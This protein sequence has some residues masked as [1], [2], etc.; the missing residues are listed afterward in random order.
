M[1]DIDSI[2]SGV[3]GNTRAN[4]SELG[5]ILPSYWA[6]LDQKQKQLERNVFKDGIPTNPD[7]SPNYAEA[8]K[9][10]YQIGDVTQ[11]NALSNLDIQRQQLKL[12]QDASA[13]MGQI[14]SGNASPASGTTLPPSAS[15]NGSAVVAPPISGGSPAPAASQKGGATLMQLVAASGIPNDQLGA[16]T[17]SLGRQLGVDDPN[18]LI[19]VNDPQVRNVLVPAIQRLKQAGIGQVVPPGQAAPQMPQ[20]NSAP[21][22]AA[23]PA[24]SPTAQSATPAPT[25]SDR[26]NPA[27][28]R[29]SLPTEMDPDIQQ[30]AAYYTQIIGNPA[31]PQSTRDAAKIRL[32]ALQKNSELTG[33][34]KE[35][36][37]AQRQGYKG[38]LQDFQADLESRKTAATEEAKIGAKK[39]ET[40]IENGI[41]AQREIPQLELM[42]TQMNDPNF[43]SGAGEKYN[44]LYKRLKSAVGIDPEAPVPQEMLRKVTSA[45]ILGSLGSLKGLGQIR[46]AEINLAK[47]AAA[48]PPNSI[49]ANKFLIETSKRTHQRNADI[50]EMAQD[51]KE[52]NGTLDAGFDKMV[53]AY[54]KAH[55]LFSNAEIKDWHKIIGEAKQPAS[56][57]TGNIQRFASPND[58]HAA[59][60]SGRIK[61]GDKFTDPNGVVRIVP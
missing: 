6:G 32:E 24:P 25:F 57:Q 29:G 60:A 56:G 11:G 45:N 23:Q 27:N 58:V 59:L 3:S 48:S 30:R 4:F 40:L 13:R 12:G 36:A 47:D 54:G 42:Q 31:F 39:Y 55:P 33:T 43:F 7:G 50:A 46:V 19:D 5:N 22:P 26:F 17:A 10:L 8:S 53:T 34:Q 16:A 21:A 2:I 1:A 41:T 14:E 49:P 9:R 18:A 38:T 35:Y 20:Q 44:L 28:T 52:K 15:R 51:Y 61:K 37:Q